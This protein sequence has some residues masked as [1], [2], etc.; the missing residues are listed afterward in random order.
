MYQKCKSRELITAS[1]NFIIYKSI[2]CQQFNLAKFA[3]LQN[4]QAEDHFP[5][6]LKTQTLT[7][8]ALDNFKNANINGLC[9]KHVHDTAI[10]VFQVKTLTMKSKPTMSLR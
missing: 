7:I 3:V 9:M 10:I 4:F 2:K 8:A 6:H 5:I 1:N